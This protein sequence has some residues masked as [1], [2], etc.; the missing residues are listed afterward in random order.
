METSAPT[1]AKQPKEPWDT[2][3]FEQIY[4]AIAVEQGGWRFN[5]TEKKLR[6]AQTSYESGRHVTLRDFA[7]HWFEFEQC[8]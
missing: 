5:Q 2:E 8:W 4:N 7:R 1:A 6:N 3:R